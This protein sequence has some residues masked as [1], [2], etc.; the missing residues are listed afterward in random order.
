VR[1]WKLRRTAFLFSFFAFRRSKSS[2]TDSIYGSPKSQRRG[3]KPDIFNDEAHMSI[4]VSPALTSLSSTITVFSLVG[5]LDFAWFESW[6]GSICLLSF[7]ISLVWG[8]SFFGELERL[9]TV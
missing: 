8:F 3:G 6:F 4:V 5:F 9:H 1:W 7:G 2:K